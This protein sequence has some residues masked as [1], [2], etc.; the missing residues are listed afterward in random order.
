VTPEMNCSSLLASGSFSRVA[1]HL[2]GGFPGGSKVKNLPANSGDA[3]SISGLGRYPGGGNSNP[4]Q[5]PCLGN[6]MDGGVW[7]VTVHG[8]AKS[9]T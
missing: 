8:V 9:Q 3:G 5:Y 2:E 1:Y 4:L 7:Q 6:P